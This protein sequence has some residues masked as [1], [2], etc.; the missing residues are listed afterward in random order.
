[1]F[2]IIYMLSISYQNGIIRQMFCNRMYKYPIFLNARLIH[3]CIA[4]NYF[5]INYFIF[6]TYIITLLKY[7]A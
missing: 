7:Y 3:L 5:M 4:L 1:M 2:Y 6:N